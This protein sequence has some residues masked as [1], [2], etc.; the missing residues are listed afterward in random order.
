VYKNVLDSAQQVVLYMRKTGIECV[1]F[2]NKVRI[3]L[4]LCRHTPLFFALLPLSFRCLCLSARILTQT[5]PQAL[6]EKILDY[7]LNL[8]TGGALY[9]SEIADAIHQLWKDPII[10]KI[11]EEHSSDFYLNDS[12]G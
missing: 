8:E 3:K 9:F 6:A 11:M 7:R 1:E 5:S 12:A 4:F 10:P 2:S